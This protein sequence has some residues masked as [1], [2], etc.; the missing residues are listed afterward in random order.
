MNSHFVNTPG[1][2]RPDAIFVGA[3]INSLVTA[4]LLG[5]AGPRVLVLGADFDRC[6]PHGPVPAAI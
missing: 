4:Y 2:L 5:K 6:G 3:G 1:T